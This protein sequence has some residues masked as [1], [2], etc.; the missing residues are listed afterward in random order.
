MKKIIVLLLLFSINLGCSAT[1]NDIKLVAI[2]D[3]LT[4]GTGDP[5]KKGYM[6]RVRAG[7]ADKEEV[8]VHLKNYAIPG[9]TTEDLLNQLKNKKMRQQ[10]KKADYLILFIGT[11]DFRKS[12]E[13]V[14]QPLDFKKMSEG[15]AKFSSNLH[16]ILKKIRV[17]NS[18]APILVLGLY[19]PYVEY[20]NEQ[21]IRGVIEGWNHEIKMVTEG[22]DAT[23]FVPILD[24]FVDKAKKQYFSDSLHPNAAGYELMA[25]RVL[26]HFITKKGL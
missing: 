9:Y 16:Q 17:E 23:Y 11:N 2:G 14:F 6:E 1:E 7:L 12:A 22:F 19:H 4:H 20:S 18:Q 5:S 26:E 25:E 10:V 15:K 13:Y 24:L 3:S 21:E 8:A